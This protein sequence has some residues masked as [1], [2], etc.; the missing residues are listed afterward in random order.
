MNPARALLGRLGLA[1][2]RPSS[3][4]LLHEDAALKVT[5]IDRPD[6]PPEWV[7][8]RIDEIKLPPGAQ[9]GAIVRG[10]EPAGPD[11]PPPQVIIPH[12]DTVIER[13]DHVIVF[14][15]R[16]R[17]VRDVEKLFQVGATFLF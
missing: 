12:H 3:E 6:A 17:Q 5:A 15:P 2:R 8:R 7:G 1:A 11:S 4:R 9:I 16:K 14:V 13:D 10:A